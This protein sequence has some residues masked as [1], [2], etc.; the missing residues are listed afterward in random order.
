[1]QERTALDDQLAALGRIERDIED[2]IGMIEL[3]E[4]EGDRSVV[5]DAEA[6]LKALRPLISMVADLM[7]ASSPGVSSRYST[8]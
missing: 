3:G 1:M 8:L 5:A 7:P 4:Q 2:N 6:A